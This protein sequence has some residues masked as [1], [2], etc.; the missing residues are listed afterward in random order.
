MDD[1]AELM[2]G[3]MGACM[4]PMFILGLLIL[5]LGLVLWTLLGFPSLSDA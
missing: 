5:V 4:Y 1:K 2:F 3:F